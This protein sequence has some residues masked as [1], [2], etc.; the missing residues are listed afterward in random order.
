MG[1]GEGWEGGEGERGEGE[2]GEGQCVGV[3]GE[4]NAK[5]KAN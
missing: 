1:R 5:Q 4:W 3:G 2:R